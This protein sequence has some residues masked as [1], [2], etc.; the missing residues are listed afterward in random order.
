MTTIP[1]DP[2]TTDFISDLATT[3]ADTTP[4]LSGLSDASVTW[5]PKPT[6]WNTKEII[7][8]LIDSA[9][10]N[11]QRFVRAAGQND[12]VFPGYAQDDW[13]RLQ[14]YATEPWSEIVTLWAAYNR[15]LARVM[16]AVPSDVRYRKH[17]K[18]NMQQL[19]WQPYSADEPASLDDLMRDYVLHLKHHLS[20]VRDRVQ[21][22]AGGTNAVSE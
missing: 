5:R 9:A 10:N 15:H 13:V 17:A 7:G 22:A 3:V 4:W 14:G 21:G 1:A 6:A 8:H 2:S 11:H 20:Q 12:L 18:H 19:G 16:A